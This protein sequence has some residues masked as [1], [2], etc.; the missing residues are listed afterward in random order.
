MTRRSRKIRPNLETLESR[1]LLT[2]ASVTSGVLY[3]HGTSLG[4]TII[5]RRVND[6]SVRPT[7]FLTDMV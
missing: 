1:C 5:V 2:T 4:D 3:I 6:V 7:A